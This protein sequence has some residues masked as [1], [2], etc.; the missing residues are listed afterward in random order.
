MKKDKG[1]PY[2]DVPILNAFA[3]YI[4]E[5]LNNNSN[6]KYLYRK[7]KAFAIFIDHILL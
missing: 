4:G 1:L 7:C 2:I 5:K 6:S 3:D